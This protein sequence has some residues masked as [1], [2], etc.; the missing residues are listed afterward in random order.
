M[1]L[2]PGMPDP[3]FVMSAEG[4]RLA[5]YEFGGPDAP[6]VFAVHGFASSAFANWQATGWIRELTRAGFRVVTL[7]QRG[8]GASDKPHDPGAYTMEALVD[9]VLAVRDAYLLDEMAFVGYSLGARVGWHAAVELHVHITRAV[10][11][12]IPDGDPLTRFDVAAARAFIADGTPIVDRLTATYLEMAG[13]MRGNDLSALVSLVEGMRGGP[14]PD[15]ANP[16]Q[17]P[18]L[19]ATGSDDPIL[20]QSRALAEAVPRGEFFEVPGRGHF[21]A[22]TSR[23]LRARALAF[24]AAR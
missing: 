19:F 5:T 13:G 20:A 1:S 17:Q 8:H 24:L 3:V 11:G 9:D 2:L 4:Y 10:L 6:V 7:D 15:A 12:G 23:E 21:S 22:P 18:V 14:Q 16:P